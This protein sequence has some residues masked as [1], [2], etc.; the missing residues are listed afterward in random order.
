MNKDD[1]SRRNF[2]LGC[3]FASAV[4]AC[5]GAGLPAVLWLYA[6]N[7]R[8][9][10]SNALVNLPTPFQ[11][12]M[13]RG[14]VARSDWGALPPDHAAFNEFGFYSLENPEGWRVY[15]VPL[16][17][18]YQTVIIHHSVVYEADD[19]STLLE[20]QRSHREQ[21]GWADVA[22]HYFVGQN[23][24]LYEGRDIHARGTHVAGY[25]TGSV[26]VC[27]LGNF[28]E[29]SPT[30]AQI[31]T[32]RSLVSWLTANLKATYLAGHGDFNPQT[33]CPGINLAAYLDDFAFNAGLV[34]GVEGYIAP[35][36]QSAGAFCSI[37]GQSHA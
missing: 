20:I 18:A 13:V 22:Y 12:L 35:P 28:V 10:I 5:A 24:V 9:R 15:D 29:I 32:T 6:Q 34:R 37:C 7:D 16:D 23:G 17:Q 31:I 3:A 25:N 36:E 21:R 14:M 27:L 30:E 2:L 19:L 26:G 1:I 11:S 8:R 33:M 4:G